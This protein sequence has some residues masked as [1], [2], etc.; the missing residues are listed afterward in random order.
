ML[1]T[2]PT[3]IAM[4]SADSSP[5]RKTYLDFFPFKLNRQY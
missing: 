3:A 5:D 1:A 2:P 4:L